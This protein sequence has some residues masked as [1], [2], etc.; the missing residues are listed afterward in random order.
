MNLLDIQNNASENT[1]IIIKNVIGAFLFKGGGLLVSLISTPLFIKY[2]GDNE[3]LGVWFT[4][5]SILFWILNFDLG[6]GN[7]IRN[8]LVK[9]LSIKDY[10]S[11]RKTISSGL[12]AVG[13][14]TIF[15]F[16][17]GYLLINIID[18][19]WLFNLDKNSIS[20]HS[21]Y[22]STFF[23]FLAIIIRFFLTV[24]T[25]IIYALQ[26]SAI[27]NFIALCV[28]LL[29]LIYLLIFDFDNVEEALITISFAYIFLSNIPTIIA[30]VLVFTK[31]ELRQ[32]KPSIKFVDKKHIKAITR[33]G[34][35]FFFCQIL[36][37]IIANTNEFFI[38]NLYGPE[39]TTEYTFYYKMT[40]IV[41]M[42]VTLSLN[43][44]WS[45]VTK[46]QS[47]GNYIWLEKL[48]NKIKYSGLILLLLQFVLI[49]FIPFLM[50]LWL[51]DGIID[52][53]HTT[54]I[55][56]AFF[57]SIFLYSGMLSTMANGLS[58]MKPQT[59]FYLL[60]VFLK[61]LMLLLLS[62]YTNWDFVVWTNF[63]IL[64]PYV[65]FQQIS[66]NRLFIKNRI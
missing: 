23:V 21:L 37:M 39:Y 54:A 4:L 34:F 38:T 42:V 26:K 45:V 49:P 13:V 58:M 5:L 11:A 24:V 6:I 64:I 7:G 40:T 20:H 2:F 51:G 17:L 30:G 1:R 60:A 47:E 50:D 16:V 57:N 22:I 18:L 66:L 55:S 62:K 14:L 28:S 43:P 31:N 29:Q 35:L 8:H 25:S 32:C 33:I 56:F 65:I 27:N 63:F 46:A 59:F 10:K 36:Y 61:I 52:V 3:I 48:Y 44:I 19:Y 12:F 53:S 15:L 9:D 41:S